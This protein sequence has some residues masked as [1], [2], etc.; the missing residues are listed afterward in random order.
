[1]HLLGRAGGFAA[2]DELWSFCSEGL[3]RIHA[4]DEEE[5]KR[6]RVLMRQYADAP[7]DLGDASMVAAAEKL[8]LRRIFTLDRHFH[9]YRALG[10]EPFEVVP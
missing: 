6:L 3:V 1:M 4:G 8:G 2:Q 9:S 7:M 5:W 10:R